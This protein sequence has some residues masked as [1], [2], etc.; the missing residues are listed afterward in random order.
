MAKT[1]LV[2]GSFLWHQAAERPHRWYLA[3]PHLRRSLQGGLNRHLGPEPSNSSGQTRDGQGKMISAGCGKLIQSERC[4][5]A[6]YDNA[7]ARSLATIG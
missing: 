3:C 1:V 5:K 7:A 6:P 2:T 4:T